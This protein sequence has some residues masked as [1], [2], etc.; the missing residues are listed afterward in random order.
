[1]RVVTIDI[2]LVNRD[3]FF[4]RYA[5]D[6]LWSDYIWAE[7]L[8]RLETLQCKQ[9]RLI[10]ALPVGRTAG[11]YELYWFSLCIRFGLRNHFLRFVS[12]WLRFVAALFANAHEHSEFRLNIYIVHD[13]VDVVDSLLLLFWGYY[14]LNRARYLL[15]SRCSVRLLAVRCSRICFVT[16]II[17]SERIL[18]WTCWPVS[19]LLCIWRRLFTQ[20]KTALGRGY[21]EVLAPLGVNFSRHRGIVTGLCPNFGGLLRFIWFRR[22]WHICDILWSYWHNS[23]KRDTLFPGLSFDI[24]SWLLLFWCRM[25]LPWCWLALL[26]GSLKLF[27]TLHDCPVGQALLMFDCCHAILW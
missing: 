4:P 19:L 11:G 2:R 20:S 24:R 9:F 23:L 10:R 13:F 25:L 7:L 1:M 17:L 26:L 8:C 15:S 3:L 27:Q 16:L 12:L 22:Y 6:I 5:F 21:C 18:F 14:F